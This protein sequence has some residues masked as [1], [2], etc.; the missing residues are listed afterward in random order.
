MYL[1]IVKTNDFSD[2]K[3]NDY[4][5]INLLL[6]TLSNYFSLFLFI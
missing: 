5:N 4:T 1:Y 6:I 2:N 3:Y